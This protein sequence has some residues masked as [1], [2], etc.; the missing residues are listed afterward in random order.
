V[1]WE[2]RWPQ[3]ASLSSFRALAV[4]LAAVTFFVLREDIGLPKVDL[5]FRDAIFWLVLIGLLGLALHDEPLHAGLSLLTVLGGC[6][7]LLFTLMQSRTMIW[8]LEGGQLLLGLAISYL[9]VSRG[10]ASS[11]WASTLKRPGEDA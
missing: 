7:L 8:L 3:I 1:S 6:E 9:I 4:A 10:L 5:L 2:E 11:G